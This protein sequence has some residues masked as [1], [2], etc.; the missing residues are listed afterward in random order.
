MTNR[1]PHT[2]KWCHFLEHGMSTNNVS[3]F[4]LQ[5]LK[6]ETHDLCFLIHIWSHVVYIYIYT[7]YIH[8]WN[9]NDPGFDYKRSCFG[10]FNHQ[11]RG[12]SQV[13]GIYIYTYVSLRLRS[14]VCIFN[15]ISQSQR[16]CW[17]HVCFALRHPKANLELQNLVHKWCLALVMMDVE[18]LYLGGFH[19]GLM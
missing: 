7:N 11:N 4:S 13:P 10:G 8:T 19:K 18:A 3:F 17:K 2:L 16:C 5:V 6:S 1:I 15:M 9:P 12:R 14:R